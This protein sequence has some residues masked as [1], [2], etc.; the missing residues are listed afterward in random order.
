MLKPIKRIRLYEEIQ[1]QIL[2]LIKDKTLKPGDR[3]PPE[4][5]LAEELNVSRS[6]IREALRSLESIGYIE[7]NGGGGTFIRSISL[8]DVMQPFS[9]VLSQDEKLLLDLIEVRLLLESEIVSL[10]ANRATEND[11]LEIESALN[12]MQSEI[13]EG[14]IGV[15]GDNHFHSALAK[16][17][18]NDAMS[19]IL[20][21]C[22]DLLSRT[23]QATLEIPGQPEK[24]LEDHRLIFEAI[25][26][27]DSRAASRA[28]KDHLNKAYLNL[29]R[30]STTN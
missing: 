29:K 4:R 12:E 6:A 17:A 24:S 5:K 26:G 14:K 27:K 7:S 22:A 28:M 2:E 20:E 18:G 25:K 10:C 21:M 23:R 13:I 1:K 3:L 9:A 15:D 16:A 11:L 30:Q 8:E 19:Y